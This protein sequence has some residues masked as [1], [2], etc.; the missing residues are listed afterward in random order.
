M[1]GFKAIASTWYQ[2]ENIRGFNLAANLE[3]AGSLQTTWAGYESSE[4]AML[5]QLKQFSSMILTADYSWSG[6]QERIENLPYNP[7]ELF[8]RIYNPIPSPLSPQPGLTFGNSS[9][10]KV[11]RYRFG[12]MEP[13]SLQHIG[14]GGS[15]C[16]AMLSWKVMAKSKRL[17]LALS[18][19][20]MAED[21]E[22]V[23]DLVLM[24][25]NGQT[26]TYPLIYGL[27]VRAESD[28]NPTFYGPSEKGRTVFDVDLGGKPIK[29]ILFV[30]KNRYVGLTIHGLSFY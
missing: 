2:P 9:E 22:P 30:A 24:G 12:T 4:P 15:E 23:A 10:F 27:H 28:R 3:Q 20:I 17:A 29:Q 26:T 14:P 19:K 18:T 7:A 21:G 25:E 6:R 5:A 13:A 8:A 1:D 16:P 11:G